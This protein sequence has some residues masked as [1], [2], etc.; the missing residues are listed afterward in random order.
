VTSPNA[1]P[2]DGILSGALRLDVGQRGKEIA[3]M[4]LVRVSLDETRGV[5]LLLARAFHREPL[6]VEMLPEDAARERLAPEHFSRVTRLAVAT[7]EVWRTQESD[8]VACWIAPGRW[9]PTDEEIAAAGLEE[10]PELVGAQ[11]WERFRVVYE[12]M[13]AAHERA[14]NVPH[15]ILWLVAVDPDRQGQGIGTSLLR[16]MLARADETGTPCYLETLDGRTVS[17]YG[18]LGFEVAEDRVEPTSG[19]R[20]WCCV[21]EPR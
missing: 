4:S 15:W 6:M 8:G 7:G 18:R 14:L 2:G 10:I 9:P 1:G 12:A 20:F 17:L 16:P 19:L 5:G 13:D 11:A 3:A 21:R